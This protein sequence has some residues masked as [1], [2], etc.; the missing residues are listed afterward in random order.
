MII[1]IYTHLFPPRYLERL[2]RT[3]SALGGIATRMKGTPQIIN[4]DARFVEMDRHG[5]YVQVISLPHPV[6]EE[7]APP[8]ET[9]ELARMA[10]DEMAEIAG[11]HPD[12]FPAWVATVALNDVDAALEETT[13]AIGLGAR[14]IQIYTNV[15][16]R[17][18]DL[19]EFRPLFEIMADHDLP[20]WLH[21]ARTAAMTDYKSEQ[22]SRY[23]MWW[24]FG[25]PYETSVAMAR[26]AF[27]GVFDRHPTLKIITH[28]L[29][30]MIPYFDGRLGAG[31]AYL[32]SRTND[33][34][35]SSV[36]SSLKKPHLD[37]FHMFYA[38]TAL[39]GGTAGLPSGLEFFGTDHITFA[40]DAPFAPIGATL[41]A[42]KRVELPPT[43]MDKILHGNAERLLRLSL[44]D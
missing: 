32:G 43:E 16:G 37:Y 4:L 38:D 41:D 2:S 15:A 20:I 34:D 44:L 31:M 28:H 42:L 27:S 39:F 23:E 19:P 24:C 8:S 6:I 13:R 18:L 30:G 33:E 29:G 21:P 14:G 7:V 22:R 35:Y 10:N 1:D 40:T 3:G 9:Q 12:R 5:D 26:L 17:P 11:R 25:W 36:L